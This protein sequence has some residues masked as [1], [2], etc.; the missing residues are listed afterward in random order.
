MASQ[1]E[2]QP[3]Q[4]EASQRVA[5]EGALSEDQAE[6]LLRALEADQEHRR[7][8]RTR[9]EGEKGRRGAGKDW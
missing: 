3:S 1:T 8:E 5:V 2:E 6:A 9:R 7:A 4:D